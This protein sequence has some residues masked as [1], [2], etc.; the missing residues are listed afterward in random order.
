MANCVNCYGT[1][2]TEPCESVGCLSTNYGK[3]ITY[4]GSN[5]FCEKGSV[6]TFTFT[7]TAVAPTTTTTVEVVATGGTGSNV[8]FNVKR[9]AGQITY[10]VTLSDGGSGYTVGDILT[11]AGTA[12][13]GTSPANNIT[14]TVSTLAAIISNGDNLDEIIENFNQRLCLIASESPSGIDY[15][16]FNYGCLRLGGNLESTGSAIVTAQGFVESTAAALCSLNTRLKALEKPAITVASCFTG[17]LTSGTST[18]VQILN[19]YGSKICTHNTNLNMTGVTGNPCIG[20]SWTSKPTSNNISEYINWV[21]TN[22][23]GIFTLLNGNIGAVS[24][25]EQE[26]RTYI[27]GTTTGTIPTSINT[28]CLTGGSTTSSLKDAMTLIVSQLCST[29]ST[30]SGLASNSYTVSYGSCFNGTYPSNSVFNAQSLG[31]FTSTTTLQNHLNQIASALGALNI[32]F[33]SSQFTINSTSCGPTI[34]LLSGSTFTCSSLSTCTLENMGDVTYGTVGTNSVLTRVNSTTWGGTRIRTGV[35][36]RVAGSTQQTEW[37]VPYTYNSSGHY[38]EGA[39][40]LPIYQD[41]ALSPVTGGTFLTG[42]A[43]SIDLGRNCPQYPSVRH[44]ES[45]GLATF[46]S[47]TSGFKLTNSAG[48][49]QSIPNN[50][51]V[52]CFQAT[53]IGLAGGVG[54]LDCLV[55]VQHFTSGGTLSGVYMMT[56]RISDSSGISFIRLFNYTGSTISLNSGDYFQI[57]MGGITWSVIA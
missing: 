32:K 57:T 55:P 35:Y 5:L 18:L 31:T 12:L 43:Y 24:V 52:N 50:Q 23:C 45:S 48:T 42:G 14:I 21:S 27:T 2:T 26:I 56:L 28:S 25:K 11:I 1:N 36:R 54:S 38:I 20:Y 6:N 16:G 7:G 37:S 33:N 47:G 39:I 4:S 29:I 53:S 13:G 8:K 30:V 51:G 44:F 40:E 49:T 17:T 9:T 10:L 22:V 19:E 3:C 15:T 46:Q 34:S 41:S